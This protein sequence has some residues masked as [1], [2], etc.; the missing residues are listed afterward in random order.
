MRKESARVVPVRDDEH[1][2]LGQ[3][4]DVIVMWAGKERRHLKQL[5]HDCI[6]CVKYR[7]S[8]GRHT[9]SRVLLLSTRLCRT[10]GTDCHCVCLT[11]ET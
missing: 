9:V 4:R 3:T 7:R 10:R 6:I 1:I 11:R 8:V 5:P 2:N